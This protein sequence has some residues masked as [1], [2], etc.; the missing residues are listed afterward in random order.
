MHRLKSKTNLIVTECST[1]LYR[2]TYR[3]WS[4]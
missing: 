3:D 4:R 2:D 1:V